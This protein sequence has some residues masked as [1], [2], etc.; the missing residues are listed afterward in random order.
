MSRRE[1]QFLCIEHISHVCGTIGLLV[2]R[3][4]SMMWKMRMVSLFLESRGEERKM[5]ERASVTVNV[6][7]ELLAVMPE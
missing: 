7:C 4:S 3:A 6:K 5:S 1:E 2:S